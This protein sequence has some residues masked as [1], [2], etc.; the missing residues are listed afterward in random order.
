[1]KRS[2]DPFRGRDVLLTNLR[3]GFTVI[4]YLGKYFR[5]I[6]DG[7]PSGYPAHRTVGSG[8]LCSEEIA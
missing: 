8:G 3:Y 6:S 5:A 2:H 1:M 7:W 4:R